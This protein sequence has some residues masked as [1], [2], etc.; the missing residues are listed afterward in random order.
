MSHAVFRRLDN[1]MSTPVALITNFEDWDSKAR[2]IA[3]AQRLTALTEGT[4]LVV[5]D[6]DRI[7][8]PR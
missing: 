6:D 2:A 7:V 8:W 4:F 5:D 3:H 1:D